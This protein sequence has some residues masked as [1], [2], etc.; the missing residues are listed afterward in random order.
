MFCSGD[1]RNAW[2][3]MRKSPALVKR[4]VKRLVLVGGKYP[5]G[6]EF[7]FAASIATDT[8]P[9][10]IKEVVASWPGPVHFAGTETGDDMSSCGCL[11]TAEAGGPLKRIYELGMGGKNPIRPST[12]LAGALYA[13]RGVQSYWSLVTQGGYTVSEDGTSGWQ[14]V[15]DTEQSVLIRKGGPEAVSAALDSLICPLTKP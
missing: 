5:A 6:R 7:N 4:K 14:D 8:L 1:V 11:A 9:N 13:V 12:D 15:L 3:L 10:M 2:D